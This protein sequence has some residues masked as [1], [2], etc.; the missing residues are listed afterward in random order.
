MRENQDRLKQLQ[1][2]KDDLSYAL[3]LWREWNMRLAPKSAP[4]AS[5]SPDD[6]WGAAVPI[7]MEP[8]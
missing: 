5:Q 8:W 2:W 4:R 1:P 3:R 7:S 6:E